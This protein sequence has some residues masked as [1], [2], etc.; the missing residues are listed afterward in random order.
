MLIRK[1]PDIRYSE[2][3][4]KA[5]YLRR[6]EFIRAASGGAIAVAAALTRPRAAAQAAR[7]RGFTTLVAAVCVGVSVH[8]VHGY[9]TKSNAAQLLVR[10]WEA[11]KADRADDAIQLYTQF[12]QLV[13]YEDADAE[14]VAA[15]TRNSATA[16]DRWIH[17]AP[18]STAGTCVP[19]GDSS[20]ECSGGSSRIPGR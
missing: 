3:T 19:M 17:M 15:A 7:G 5:L 9:F 2:I 18:S 13:D 11:D 8:L 6:R 10:G 4:P 14:A 16:L 20:R 12:L 1:S